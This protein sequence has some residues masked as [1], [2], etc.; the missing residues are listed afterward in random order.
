MAEKALNTKNFDYLDELIEEFPN[1]IKKLEDL[2]IAHLRN[3]II[4]QGGYFNK[5]RRFDYNSFLTDY[6]E[7]IDYKIRNTVYLIP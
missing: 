7:L 3:L 4:Y 5:D 1:Y 6:G 2:S